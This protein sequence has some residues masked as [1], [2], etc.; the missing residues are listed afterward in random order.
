MKLKK[1]DKVIAGGYGKVLEIVRI[2]GNY[3]KLDDGNTW[4]TNSLRL[5]TTET[6][7]KEGR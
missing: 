7:I 5:Q 2:Y 3:A 6:V 4:P 1:G